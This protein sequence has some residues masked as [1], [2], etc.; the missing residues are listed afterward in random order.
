MSNKCYIQKN[1]IWVIS[2]IYRFQFFF[3]RKKKTK[4]KKQNKEFCV[5]F[6]KYI[7]Y[8][9]KDKRVFLGRQIWLNPNDCPCL[10]G[11]M[12]LFKTLNYVQVQIIRVGYELIN[13][14]YI[15]GKGAEFVGVCTMLIKCPVTTHIYL[16]WAKYILHGRNI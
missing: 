2:V 7:Y 6:F 13:R 3:L 1:F 11:G 4:T 9:R 5:F 14:R 8:R 16:S 15:L 12:S 10:T